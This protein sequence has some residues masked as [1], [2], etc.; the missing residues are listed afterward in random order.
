MFLKAKVMNFF[1][2]ILLRWPFFR[3]SVYYI[4]ALLTL[5]MFFSVATPNTIHHYEAGLV[6]TLFF[7]LREIQ[8]KKKL[9]YS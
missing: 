3:D 4:F 8:P 1:M 5:G 2:F 9:S 7:F 6:T